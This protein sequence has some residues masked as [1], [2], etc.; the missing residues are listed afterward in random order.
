MID[1]KIAA[2]LLLWQCQRLKY[3]L[4]ELLAGEIEDGEEEIYWGKPEGEEVW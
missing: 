1:D 4:D 3:S 2:L